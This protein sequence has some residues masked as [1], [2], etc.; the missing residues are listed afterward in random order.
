MVRNKL[1][2]TSQP[3]LEC[4]QLLFAGS[5]T[6][7]PVIVE[8]GAEGETGAKGEVDAEVECV[9]LSPNSIIVVA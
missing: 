7:A 6:P 3:T 2:T 1:R 8:I 4:R 5:L 9:D